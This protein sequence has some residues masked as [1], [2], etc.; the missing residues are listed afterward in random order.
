MLHGKDILYFWSL[1]WNLLVSMKT[2]TDADIRT[3]TVTE[4]W[5]TS[6][7]PYSPF[8]RGQDPLKETEK[9]IYI[10]SLQSITLWFIEQSQEP[11]SCEKY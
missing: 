6:H 1:L 8:P 2:T 4:N 5:P 11:K 7:S 10:R 3:D 9:K